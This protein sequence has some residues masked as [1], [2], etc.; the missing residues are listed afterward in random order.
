M[1]IIINL[2]SKNYRSLHNFITKVL[3]KNF[4]SKFKIF[5]NEK[6]IKTPTKSMLY[7]VLKSPHVNKIAQE[8]FI[9]KI[10]TIK[11]KIF[12]FQ[13]NLLLIFLKT[14][15]NILSSDI[16]INYKIILN[17]NLYKQN[18]KILFNT[19]KLYFYKKKENM[20]LLKNFLI[21]NSMH[22]EFLLKNKTFR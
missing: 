13:P 8:Q 14:I 16:K 12:F 5:V 21:F 11:L 9:Y 22:G 15:K 20:F 2:S 18:L 7:S 1:I 19:K 4:I 17:K 3:N 10:Y 6:I